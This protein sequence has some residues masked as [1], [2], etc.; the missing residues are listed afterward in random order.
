[1]LSD[2]AMGSFLQ[3]FSEAL[4]GVGNGFGYTMDKDSGELEEGKT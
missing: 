2:E 1:V 4:L 3:R